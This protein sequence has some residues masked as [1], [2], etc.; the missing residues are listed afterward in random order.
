MAQLKV[1]NMIKKILL[2]ISTM[3]L[4]LTIISCSDSPYGKEIEEDL[5]T[6]NIIDDNYRNYYEIYVR[7]FYDSNGD[8]IGDLNGVT[9]KLDYIKDLGFNGIWLMPINTSSSY[10]K[11]NVKD[12]YEIDPSY[13]TM[14][15]LKI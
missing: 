4:A 13:G 6:T 15:D 10:H 2:L 14:D 11:Y 1:R 9:A 8:G 12:Y 3:I 7:S 5:T